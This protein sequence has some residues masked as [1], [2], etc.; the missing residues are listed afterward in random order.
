MQ[1]DTVAIPETN[2][3]PTPERVFKVP[4]K[5][6]AE[7]YLKE[8]QQKQFVSNEEKQ[9]HERNPAWYLGP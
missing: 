6:H 8:G 2:V 1:I 4:F 9:K 7:A 3:L 5:S